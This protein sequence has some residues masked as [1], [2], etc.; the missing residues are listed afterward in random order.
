MN[1]IYQGILQCEAE[2]TAFLK[3]DLAANSVVQLRVVLHQY[4]IYNSNDQIQSIL[5]R[6]FRLIWPQRQA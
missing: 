3:A 1:N 4:E 5:G 2:K 6:A